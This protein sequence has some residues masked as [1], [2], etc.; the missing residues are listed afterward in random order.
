MFDPTRLDAR[1]TRDA[2][3]SHVRAVLVKLGLGPSAYGNAEKPWGVEFRIEP[4]QGRLF[5][6]RCFDGCLVPPG[7]ADRPAGP[8]LMLIRE[9]HRL[10]W[11]YHLRKDA[12][13]R[14]LHGSVGAS[15]SPDDRE[16]AP[17][18]LLPGD[19]VRIP[20]LTRHRLMSLSGWSVIAEIAR[21]DEPEDTVRL[22]DDY[23]RAPDG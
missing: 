5:Y 1:A 2:A 11:H 6:E 7:F 23:G 15:L 8:N 17:D 10:S 12:F 4:D 3:I 9:A 14:I 21:V 22:R 13:L 18:V 19:A 16:R 20:P